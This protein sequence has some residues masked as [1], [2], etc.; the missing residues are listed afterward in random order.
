MN[1]RTKV[2]MFAYLTVGVVFMAGKDTIHSLVMM[3]TEGSM[4]TTKKS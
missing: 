2:A 1:S 3:M 4:L